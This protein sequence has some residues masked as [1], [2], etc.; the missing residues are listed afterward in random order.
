MWKND[1]SKVKLF[2]ISI[3]SMRNFHSVDPML[4]LIQPDII[5]SENVSN[6]E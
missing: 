1:S 5:Q 2:K 3:L 4:C 6:G